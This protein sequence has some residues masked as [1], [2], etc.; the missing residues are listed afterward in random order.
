MTAQ[1]SEV[2]EF[3]DECL[4]MSTLPLENYVAALV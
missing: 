1:F 3:C 2:L 4:A